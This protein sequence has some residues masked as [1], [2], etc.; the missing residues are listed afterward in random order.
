MS[1]EEGYILKSDTGNWMQ[2]DKM[3]FDMEILALSLDAPTPNATTIYINELGADVANQYAYNIDYT[4]A[5]VSFAY[6]TPATGKLRGTISATGLKPFAT[7]QVKFEGKPICQYGASGNDLANEY[8][9]FEGR[10]T[11]TSG[12]TC[13]GNAAARNRSDAQYSALSPLRGNGS[14][15]IT[16]YLVWGFFTADSNGN[17]VK[18][19]ET[20]SSYHVLFA[21]GGVCGST[22]NLHLSYLDPVHPTVLFAA[23]SDVEGQIERGFCGGL[24]LNPGNY[25]LKIVLTEESFHQ[26]NWA[27]VLGKDI[28]FSIQ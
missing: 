19:I 26:G 20:V 1:V 6:D 22:D 21:N 3:S 10:W 13:T 2:S 5:D 24:T 4:K 11:C 8:I 9:G 14:E 18:T 27:T 25:D 28:S 23:A 7:Y 16:S 15:C 12:A 17:A